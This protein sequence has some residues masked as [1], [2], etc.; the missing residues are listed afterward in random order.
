MTSEQKAILDSMRARIE[1]AEAQDNGTKTAEMHM[2]FLINAPA[3]ESLE[4]S[5]VIACLGL[6][7]SFRTELSKMIG[8]YNHLKLNQ[9]SLAKTF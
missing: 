8:L 3:L 4:S 1:F 2:Q 9:I 6:S 7:D 5:E